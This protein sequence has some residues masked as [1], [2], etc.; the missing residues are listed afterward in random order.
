MRTKVIDIFRTT[1]APSRAQRGVLCMDGEPL[2]VTLELP[3]RENAK[4]ISCIPAGIYTCRR[5]FKRTTKGGME[6]PE[7]FEIMRVS[8]RSGVLFHVGNY[9]HDT[10]GCILLGTSFATASPDPMICQSTSAFRN[11]MKEMQEV[12][13]FSLRIINAYD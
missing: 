9:P 13:D 7:T 4:D 6:I 8:N 12:N 2:C 1:G 10:H 11:F 5:T 3:W